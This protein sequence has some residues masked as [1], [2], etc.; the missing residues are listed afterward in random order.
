MAWLKDV[1][2]SPVEVLPRDYRPD[3]VMCQSCRFFRRCWQA[4][5]GADDRH[6]LFLDDPDAAA[7]ATR[8]ED[9]RARRKAAEADEADAKGALDHLRSVARPG[10]KEDIEVPGLAK[11]IRFHVKRG[12]QSPD[13]AMIAMDYKRAGARPPV[14]YGEPT[15][16][17]ALVKP[18]RE[19]P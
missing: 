16:G 12:R 19:T 18:K 4:E 7:W 11:L 1:R 3:S 2:E 5:P 13:M 14:K 8:L 6:V 15:V 9:A 17:I 10:D